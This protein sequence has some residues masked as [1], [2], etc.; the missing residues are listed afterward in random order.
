L[1]SEVLS[2]EGH[3]ECESWLI[4]IGAFAFKWRCVLLVDSYVSA[5][6][7]LFH[8]THRGN[9][10]HIRELARLFP[11]AVLMERANQIDLIRSLRRGY[12]QVSFEGRTIVIRDQ[13]KLHR[14]NTGVPS[15][16]T[17][18][19]LIESLNRRIFFWP[20]GTAGPISYGQRHYERYE[21]EHP[22]ILRID[23]QSLVDAN[24]SVSPLFCRYNS[25]SPRCFDGKKSP[26]GPN[27]FLPAADFHETASKVVEVTFDTEIILPPTTQFGKHPSGPWKKL[28]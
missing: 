7:Y 26:R 21:E 17:F 24:P 19:D 18:E 2:T 14:G 13:D 4:Y 12:R 16:F 15:G 25:G 20:G 23:F 11:A 8:L 5:R 6:P 9:L 10:N 1:T 27:T 3:G 28:I 22:V